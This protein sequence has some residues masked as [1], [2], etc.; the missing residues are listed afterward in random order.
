MKFFDS[1]RTWNKVRQTRNE[2]NA[3]SNHEL[4]D[5]GIARV[6]IPYIA[7]RAARG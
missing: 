2:L 4:N 1:I 6:D 7:N 5:L 3:L